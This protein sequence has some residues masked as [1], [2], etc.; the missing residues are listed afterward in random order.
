MQ[1]EK[2]QLGSPATRAEQGLHHTGVPKRRR[3]EVQEAKAKK[4][5]A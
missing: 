3:L 5:K 2:D 1:V 4:E